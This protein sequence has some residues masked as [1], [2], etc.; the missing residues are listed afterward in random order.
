MYPLPVKNLP[1][2]RT[3]Y[4]PL[5]DP[6]GTVQLTVPP[7]RQRPPTAPTPLRYLYLPLRYRPGW[8]L[9]SFFG[10]LRAAGPVRSPEPACFDAGRVCVASSSLLTSLTIIFC[11][12]AFSCTIRH[13]SRVGTL[14]V[15]AGAQKSHSTTYDDL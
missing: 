1:V 8:K 7:S 2:W 12:K 5:K 13:D 9:L 15:W 14:F 11:I 4:G 10:P 6:Y 3:N